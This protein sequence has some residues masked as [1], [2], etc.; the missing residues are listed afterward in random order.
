MSNGDPGKLGDN[1]ARVGQDAAMVRRAIRQRWR[2]PDEVR[3][4]VVSRMARTVAESPIE[5]D[6]TAAAKVLVAAEG[7]NQADEHLDAKNAR[8]DDGK[9]TESVR[10]FKVQFDE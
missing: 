5:R 8:L 1:D 2:I 3:E 10:V 7:Q 6:A 4:T 9:P